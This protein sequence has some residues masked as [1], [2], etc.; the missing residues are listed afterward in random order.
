L[1][2]QDIADL[3]SI[4]STPEVGIYEHGGQDHILLQTVEVAE[5]V[6]DG[7][8]GVADQG[9]FVVA[10]TSP[11][12]RT[13][14]PTS[15]LMVETPNTATATATI[16]YGDSN[17]PWTGDWEWVIAPTARR[18]GRHLRALGY[19][20]WLTD[21]KLTVSTRWG[22]PVIPPDVIVASRMLAGRMVTFEE[23]PL[24]VI[25]MADTA[26]YLAKRDGRISEIV[27]NIGGTGGE[28]L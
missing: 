2:N 15:P 26:R 11:T 4:L 16:T 18:P 13:F 8:C 10:P 22:I 1:G 17:T 27:A 6:I 9:G 12:A 24:G 7:L 19:D 25:A 3:K 20:R 21:C 5:N 23:I 14:W 28:W